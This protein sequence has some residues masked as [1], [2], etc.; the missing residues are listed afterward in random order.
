MTIAELTEMCLESPSK[1]VSGIQTA[2]TEASRNDLI[3]IIGDYGTEPYFM[4]GVTEIDDTWDDALRQCATKVLTEHLWRELKSQYKELSSSAYVE[5]VV[6]ALVA[7]KLPPM[8]EWSLE[9]LKNTSPYRRED[10]DEVVRIWAVISD[11]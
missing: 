8:D 4:D 3:K 5:A 7:A 10:L 11:E 2:V 1:M 6:A 9:D